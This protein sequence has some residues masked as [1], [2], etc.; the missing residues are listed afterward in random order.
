MM[1]NPSLSDLDSSGKCDRDP[2]VFL[3]RSATHYK[4][5]VNLRF[6]WPKMSLNSWNDEESQPFWPRIL[7]ET[8]LWSSDFPGPNSHRTHYKFGMNLGFF[9]PKMSVSSW[10]DEESQPFWPRLLGE[11]WPWSSSFSGPISHHYSLAWI[12][13]F[14]GPRYHSVEIEEQRDRDPRIKLIRSATHYKFGVNLGFSWP[15]LSLSWHFDQTLML[16]LL[17]W[18]FDQMLLPIPRQL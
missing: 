9:W 6:F 13:G 7:R 15:K 18:C 11:T 5:G 17:R 3:A 2:R 10:N 4:F 8:W 14:S 1:K 16:T 12:L